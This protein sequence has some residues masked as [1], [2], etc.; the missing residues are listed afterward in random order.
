MKFR[1]TEHPRMGLDTLVTDKVTTTALVLNM[2][3]PPIPGVV[4]RSALLP[5]V[6]TRGSANYP[7]VRAMQRQ[8]DFMYG[9]Y[10]NA[11]VYKLGER[12]IGQFRLEI[13]NGKYL[14]G[15]PD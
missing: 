9:S 8:L 2:Q 6:L 13:P 12:H 5:H 10:L 1:P 14:P 4:T 15:Q 7:N 3:R 11:D